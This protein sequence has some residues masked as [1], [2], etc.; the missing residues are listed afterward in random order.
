MQIATLGFHASGIPVPGGQRSAPGHQ[1]MSIR[2]NYD[3]EKLQTSAQYCTA[4]IA[5]YGWQY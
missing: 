1:Q 5:L 4:E 3:A 2:P